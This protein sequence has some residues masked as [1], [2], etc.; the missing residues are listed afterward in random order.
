LNETWKLAAVSLSAQVFTLPICIYYFHQLPV[1]FLLSNIIAI[2][3]STVALWGCIVLVFV[4][5]LHLVALYLGK[6]VSASIWLLNHIVLLVNALPFSLWDRIALSVTGTI[7][8]YMVFIFFLY[9]LIKK[10]MTA[11]KWGVLSSFIL[12]GMIAVEKWHVSHQGK[13]IVY[14]VP[15]YK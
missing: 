15:S 5:P 7:L 12:A 2:P 13:I 8:L 9:W 11:F 4:S 6:G 10:N 1:M 3:L 14:N